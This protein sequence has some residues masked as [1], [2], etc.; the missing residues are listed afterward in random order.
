MGGRALLSKGVATER[1]DTETFHSI[2]KYLRGQI[3]SDLGLDTAIVK[4]FHTK[5]DHGDLDLL[6]KVEGNTDYL[7]YI[8]ETFEPQAT[9]VNANV[10]SFDFEN[11]QIDFIM[12]QPESWETAQTYY[13]YDPLGNIMGKSYH[14]FR[15]SYGWNG[16]YYKFRNLHGSNSADIFISADAR[17]IFEFGGYDYDRYLLGFE[18]LVEIYDFCIDSKYFNVETFKMENLTQIDRKRNR[19]RL[20]YHKFLEYVGESNV[21]KAYEFNSDKDSYVSIIAEYFPE[22]DLINKLNALKEED[23]INKLVNEKFN[24]NIVMEWIPNLGGRKLGFAMGRF[25]DELGTAY[26]DYILVTDTETVKAKF[27]ELYNGEY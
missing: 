8:N 4:C 16:L 5:E 10:I 24:G 20:S 17:K 12:I 21:S 25:K 15:L 1:K 3:Y 11:F 13:S 2:A 7:K 9:Y 23:R 27:L 6:V 19:K 22:A 14:K 26:K 18:N